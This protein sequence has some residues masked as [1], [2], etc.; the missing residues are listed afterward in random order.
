[1]KQG[2]FN[3]TSPVFFK[4]KFTYVPKIHKKTRH[5]FIVCRIRIFRIIPQE[6]KFALRI[7]FGYNLLFFKVL[8]RRIIYGIHFDLINFRI[9]K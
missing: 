4:L 8:Y 5:Y 7:L 9:I 1:M 2:K 6:N 3:K